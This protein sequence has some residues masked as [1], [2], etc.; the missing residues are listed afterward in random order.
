MPQ[1]LA[2]LPGLLAHQCKALLYLNAS[3]RRMLYVELSSFYTSNATAA[4]AAARPSVPLGSL[5]PWPQ[6]TR[7]VGH[8]ADAHA[9]HKPVVVNRPFCRPPKGSQTVTLVG[10]GADAHAPNEVVPADRD[11]D[12]S[13]RDDET[14]NEIATA[15]RECDMTLRLQT[16]TATPD[17]DRCA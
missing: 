3:I 15:D 10:Q 2:P 17:R 6:V 11:C 1:Q 13:H 9:Q 5:L 7:K 12:C 8:G 16:V 4:G 14:A